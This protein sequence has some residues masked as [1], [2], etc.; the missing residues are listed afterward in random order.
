MK[1]SRN[2]RRD[3]VTGFGFVLF[4]MFL[5]PLAPAL[6]FP[7]LDLVNDLFQ[8]VGI[9]PARPPGALGTVVTVIIFVLKLMTGIVLWLVEAFLITLVLCLVLR[10]F[11]CVKD[12]QTY[13]R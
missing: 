13:G 5:T 2:T 1:V 7:V 4:A 9:S 3:F 11:F 6:S 12:R 10:I 8:A